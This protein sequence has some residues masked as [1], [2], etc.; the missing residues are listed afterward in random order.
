[1]N[2]QAT[3]DADNCLG[4]KL[5]HDTV[6][7]AAMSRDKAIQRQAT[8]DRSSIYFLGQLL[9]GLC[10]YHQDQVMALVPSELRRAY[11]SIK[12]TYARFCTSATAADLQLLGCK[13]GSNSVKH[14]E[15]NQLGTVDKKELLGKASNNKHL[16]SRCCSC[17]G[18]G[19]PF[20]IDELSARLTTQAER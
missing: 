10:D 11:F 12:G 9:E 1:M 8:L 2:L 16:S 19:E 17:K 6:E 14:Q 4:A 15:G 3:S 18:V 7:E 5:A 13:S 20:S